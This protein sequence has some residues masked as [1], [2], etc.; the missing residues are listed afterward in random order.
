MPKMQK[1]CQKCNKQCFVNVNGRWPCRK[2]ELPIEEL[3]YLIDISPN[4]RP[5]IGKGKEAA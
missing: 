1:E 4:S 3:S 5:A 2:Y